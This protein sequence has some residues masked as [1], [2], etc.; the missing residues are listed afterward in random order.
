MLVIYIQAVYN[1]IIIKSL[2]YHTFEKILMLLNVMCNFP[3]LKY[4]IIYSNNK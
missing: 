4:E 1:T 3:I 2:S